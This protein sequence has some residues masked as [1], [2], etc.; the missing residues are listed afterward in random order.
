MAKR[1]PIGDGSGLSYP[2]TTAYKQWVYAELKRREWTFDEF[3]KRIKRAGA[4]SA[5]S[6]AISQFFFGR[7]KDESKPM[8]PSNTTLMPFM[9]KVL[10]IAPPPVC[11]PT[12]ELAQLRDRVTS[13]FAKLSPREQRLV[14]SI[15]ADDAANDGAADSSTIRG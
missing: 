8:A 15:F 6:S 12:D 4:P 9:N 14:L 3:A 10:G 11:D 5:T 7:Q 2:A 1:K 13:R